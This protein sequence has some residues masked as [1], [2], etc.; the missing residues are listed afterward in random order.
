[1]ASLTERVAHAPRRARRN[2]R[3]TTAASPHIGLIPAPGDQEAKNDRLDE[4][5]ELIP[6]G[7]SQAWRRG[8]AL[9][10]EV[11]PGVFSRGPCR[12][13]VPVRLPTSFGSSLGWP[14]L[15]DLRCGGF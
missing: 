15:V 11:N 3:Q 8:K 5:Q 7:A 2:N 13:A 9:S 6:H 14:P 4:I 12:R 1:M 10:R